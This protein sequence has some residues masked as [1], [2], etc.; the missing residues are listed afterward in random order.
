MSK[1]P[2]NFSPEPT[3]ARSDVC[4]LDDISFSPIAVPEPSTA[5]LVA[6]AGL[7]LLN[8]SMKTNRRSL[9]P[10]ISEK[11]LGRAVHA[12]AVAAAAVAYRVR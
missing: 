4:G 1:L 2:L 3:A 7:A 5:A 11:K 6:L 12:Q 8:K 9:H 10:L